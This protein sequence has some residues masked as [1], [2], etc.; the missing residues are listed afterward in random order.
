MFKSEII[1]N[2]N[3]FQEKISTF[4]TNFLQTINWLEFKKDYGW[5][6]IKILF[7]N[8]NKIVGFTIILIKKIKFFKFFYIP[9]G[10]IVENEYFEN[11]LS[12]IEKIAKDHGAS[13]LKIEPDLEYDNSIK[14]F[15][16]Y[17]ETKDFIQPI[18]TALIDLRGT[19]ENLVKNVPSKKR[20][21]IKNKYD[22]KFEETTNLDDFF[23]VYENNAISQKFKSRDIGYF[24]NLLKY[25]KDDVKIFKVIKDDNVIASSLNIICGKNMTYLYSG[26][27][28]KYNNMYPGYFLV[29]NTMLWGM[30]HN[31]EI[32]DL[33]GISEKNKKWEGFSEFKLNIGGKK[34]R[35]IGSFDLYINP[36]YS[37]IY[38]YVRNII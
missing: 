17:K 4:E 8:D 35:Y 27:D 14:Y 6:N 38:K 34:F 10:P 11:A 12:E 13:L 20:G 22:L 24:K 23:M 36:I 26:S 33:W 28:K 15:E 31:I 18:D 21:R 30:E 2:N 1:E 16:K 9:R 19:K 5:D 7:K 37:Y 32:Y 3:V 29:F 25:F